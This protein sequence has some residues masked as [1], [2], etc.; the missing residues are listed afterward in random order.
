[1]RSAPVALHLLLL[2][3]RSCTAALWVL[4]PSGQVQVLLW[5]GQLLIN[6]DSS[7]Q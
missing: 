3:C 7:N 6:G 2:D 5:Q 1:M 4:K